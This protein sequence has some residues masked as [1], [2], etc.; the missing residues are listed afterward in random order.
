[1]HTLK[2][3]TTV[4]IIILMLIFLFFTKGMYLEKD[5][6]SIIGFGFME[7]VYFLSLICMWA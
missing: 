3:V 4:L 1:M 6:A 2:V 5:K 7:I